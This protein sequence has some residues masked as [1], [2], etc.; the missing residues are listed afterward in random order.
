MLFLRTASSRTPSRAASLPL[1]SLIV[2]ALCSSLAHAQAAPVPNPQVIDDAASSTSDIATAFSSTDV[3]STT[4]QSTDFTSIPFSTDFTST[5]L[6]TDFTSVVATLDVTSTGSVT[7]TAISSSRAEDESVGRTASATDVPSTDVTSTAFVETVSTAVASEIP[8][9]SSSVAEDSTTSTSE[10]T[11]TSVISTITGSTLETT[12]QAELST[13]TEEAVESTDV[14]I[15]TSTSALESPPLEPTQTTAT[16]PSSAEVPSPPESTLVANP[17]PVSST[18]EVNVP[19]PPVETSVSVSESSEIP[20]PQPTATIETRSTSALPSGTPNISAPPPAETS[21]RVGTSPTPGAPAPPPIASVTTT[22]REFPALTSLFEP[23][24]VTVAT[25][26]A[27]DD[28]LPA[29][30]VSNLVPDEPAPAPVPPT[31]ASSVPPRFEEEPSPPPSTDSPASATSVPDVE[32]ATPPPAVIVVPAN[33]PIQQPSIPNSQPAADSAQQQQSG[34]SPNGGL[35][36]GTVAGLAFVIVGGLVVGMKMRNNGGKAKT[37]DNEIPRGAPPTPGFDSNV[38][39]GPGI[40]ARLASQHSQDSLNPAMGWEP[41]HKMNVAPAPRA[42]APQI[43]EQDFNFRG[44]SLL[45]DN[46][47]YSFIQAPQMAMNS[48]PGAGPVP[49]TPLPPAP[50][51]LY[52]GDSPRSTHGVLVDSANRPISLLSDE[53]AEVVVV[54]DDPDVTQDMTPDTSLLRFMNAIPLGDASTVVDFKQQP[55]LAQVNAAAAS[56][57]AA[58]TKAAAEGSVVSSDGGYRR[59]GEIIKGPVT[60]RPLNK[61]H[62]DSM[63]SDASAAYSAQSYYRD[64][65]SDSIRD[66][67]ATGVSSSYSVYDTLRSNGLLGSEANESG[68]AVSHPIAE[69]YKKAF[70]A[71]YDSSESFLSD[72]KGVLDSFGEDAELSDARDDRDSR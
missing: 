7:A 1:R 12:G 72:G 28:R 3:V 51:P 18:T 35:I 13:Q 19:P 66:S 37:A 36:A 33:P 48:M 44:E 27:G 41:S 40:F 47:L 14:T 38:G 10:S 53:T 63:Y 32:I 5:S 46:S 60:P 69:A 31:R 21:T 20:A 58:A 17:P 71:T 24:R 54:E 61:F 9:I 2:L 52:D 45:S 57:A 50:H 6:S 65:L 68:S 15:P 42:A 30:T 4:S 8:Q 59:P 43:A 26:G 39:G 62:V 25:T 55:M 23:P 29:P 11:A 49:F 16:V 56:V 67:F 64:S 34:A 70:R 22:T